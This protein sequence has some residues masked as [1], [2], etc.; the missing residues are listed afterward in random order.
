MFKCPYCN[1]DSYAKTSKKKGKFES[2]ESVRRHVSKCKLN[3]GEYF[4]DL[5]AGL[6]HETTINNL[7]NKISARKSDILK[8]FNNHKPINKNYISS[9][10][11]DKSKLLDQIKE[12]YIKNNRIPA[13]REF[14][15]INPNVADSVTF[16]RHFGSWNNAI[17]AAGFEP[18]YNNGY[19]KRTIA[20]DG[21]LYRSKVEAYFV[22]N[23]LYGKYTYEYENKYDNHNKYYDFY[24]KE[25]DLYIEIAGG[26]NPEN[27]QQKILI[28]REEN[29]NLLVIFS[30]SI[31]SKQELKEFL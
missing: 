28:N 13:I 1:Q 26:L 25:L 23:Y 14:K 30:D 21:V 20:R 15:R 8:S 17:K 5:I 24:I 9:L 11:F 3:T 7:P 29:K 2:W 4:I 18:N 10:L 6:I 22:D 16:I 12:F 27:I 31:Y 19:G